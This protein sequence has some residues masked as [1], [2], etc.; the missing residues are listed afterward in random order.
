MISNGTYS[1]IYYTMLKFLIFFVVG[2]P[3]AT[4]LSI[5]NDEFKPLITGSLQLL[6]SS[7]GQVLPQQNAHTTRFFLSNLDCF[8]LIVGDN[9]PLPTSIS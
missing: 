7:T 5:I 3:D 4:S 6:T 8:D 9:S 1:S 2:L